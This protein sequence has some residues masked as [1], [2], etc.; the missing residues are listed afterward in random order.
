MR[1][2][3][4]GIGLG[5][6]VF[7]L[8]VAVAAGGAPGSQDAD[9]APSTRD[10]FLVPDTSAGAAARE[11][12]GAR[13]VARYESFSLVSAPAGTAPTLRAAGADKRNDLRLV[14]TEAG[15]IDPRADRAPLLSGAGGGLALVQFIGPVKDAWLAELGATGVDVITYMASDAYIVHGSAAELSAL[16]KLAADERV[17]A[18][19]DSAYRR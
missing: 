14:R 5:L 18:R 2:N 19:R 16:A 11:A 8:S 6:G 10:L 7:L 15:N 4:A 12:A 17:R 3:T 9:S 1:R 13:T